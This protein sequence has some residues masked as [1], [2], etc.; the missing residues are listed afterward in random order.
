[1]RLFDSA[2]PLDDTVLATL[3]FKGMLWSGQ[4]TLFSHSAELGQ[5]WA[6]FPTDSTVLKTG[7][8]I[9]VNVGC[10]NCTAPKVYDMPLGT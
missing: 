2:A 6:A 5:V 4:D 9:A 7:K 8:I 1:M 3:N 10:P